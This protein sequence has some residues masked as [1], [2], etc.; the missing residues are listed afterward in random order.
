MWS[1][2]NQRIK[3]LMSARAR[4]KDRLTRPIHVR[5]AD[6][7]ISFRTDDDFLVNIPARALLNDFT[8]SGFTAYATTALNPNTEVNL[9]IEHPRHFRLK[10]K[11]V[12]SQYQPSS[13]HV[14]TENSYSYRIGLALIWKD[15]ALEEEFKKFCGNLEE[16][17]VNAKALFLEE[18][19][20]GDAM[21]AATSEGA[22]VAAKDPLDV[23]PPTESDEAGPPSEEQVAA[24][25][26]AAKAAEVASEA[27]KA[28]NPEAPEAA[29]PGAGETSA[30]DVLNAL[31]D[32]E[33]PAPK[34]SAPK[35]D[36][37]PA[38]EEEKKAA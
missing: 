14:L 5:R 27:L 25:M 19:L 36:A 11:V 33:D 12:W 30:A 37:T 31:K 34:E 13:T 6:V 29:A 35:A 17:Y 9:E 28:A 23:P 20:K 38:V 3:A 10:A 1:S 16:L 32:V 22:A 18:A 15:A 4:E 8:P 21:P 2:T 24:E 7:I 26:A